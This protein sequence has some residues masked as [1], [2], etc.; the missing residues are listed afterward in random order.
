M[1]SPSSPP[2]MLKPRPV[3]P[4]CRMILRALWWESSERVRQGKVDRILTGVAYEDQ[5]GTSPSHI[6]E[7]GL[8]SL[9]MTPCSSLSLLEPA[10]LLFSDRCQVS[11]PLPSRIPECLE[12]ASQWID[13]QSSSLSGRRSPSVGSGRRSSEPTPCSSSSPDSPVL[14]TGVMEPGPQKGN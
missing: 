10:W 11:V 8:R 14:P 13:S 6:T 9:C 5:P 2:T 1:P 12:S 3:E 4:L 7:E